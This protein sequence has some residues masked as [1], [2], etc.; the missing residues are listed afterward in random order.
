VNTNLPTG[1]QIE[2][3]VDF[4]RDRIFA[5]A[6]R[7][8]V[9]PREF[10]S[11]LVLAISDSRATVIAHIGDGCVALK[12]ETLNKWCTPSW[13]DHGEYASTT[14]FVTDDPA[15][16]LRLSRHDGPICALVSFTDGLERLAL[17]FASKQPFE[18][19]FEGICRP[20]FGSSNLGRNRSLSQELKQYLNSSQI[21]ER[22]DDDKT[23]VLAVK[24]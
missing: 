19:F 2:S 24:K 13:P 11:T 5:V 20:L 17:D 10:A 1:A 3:W 23:L 21:N 16:K 14:S 9:L 22:T 15:A 8:G 18:K 4:S 7:R 12:D 6:E